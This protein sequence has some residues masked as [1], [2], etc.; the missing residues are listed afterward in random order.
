MANNLDMSIVDGFVPCMSGSAFPLQIYF[1][2]RILVPMSY[3]KR[4]NYLYR[5]CVPSCPSR[6][7]RRHLSVRPSRRRSPRRPSSVRPSCRVRPI[8]AVVVLCPSVPSSVPSS[9]VLCPCAPS[10]VRLVVR[11]IRDAHQRP[12]NQKGENISTNLNMSK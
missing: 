4:W 11:P 1:Q 5:P 3:L 2:I 10:S 7:C 12:T 9:C 6:R 8:I